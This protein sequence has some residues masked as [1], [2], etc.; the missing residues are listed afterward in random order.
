MG[1]HSSSEQAVE[2]FQKAITTLTVVL[3]SFDIWWTYASKDTRPRYSPIMD[4]Y[5]DFFRFDEEAHFRNAIIG[6][7]TLFD[8]RRDTATI[9]NVLTRAPIDGVAKRAAQ[10]RIEELKPKTCKIK[11]L[12]DKLFAHRDHRLDYEEIYALAEITPN[13][14]RLVLDECVSTI[15]MVATQLSLD[16]VQGDSFVS[17]D[18]QALLDD[19]NQEI[20]A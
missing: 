15:N 17:E 12:R 11:V 16:G 8:G 2:L 10:K 14:L 20:R 3:A 18:L 5:P 1:S 13:D 19:L 6:L 9:E 4:G 7:H